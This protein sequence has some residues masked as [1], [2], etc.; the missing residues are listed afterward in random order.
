MPTSSDPAKRERQ[1]ANLRRGGTPA[2]EGNQHRVTHGAYAAIAAE[3]LDAK[4][5]EVF[6]ALVEDAPLKHTADSAAIRVAAEC[7]CRLDNVTGWLTDHGWLD[8]DNQPRTTILEIEGRLRR[9]AADH[10]DALGMTPRS[11]AKLGV[12]IARAADLA[13]MMSD[14]T[15]G[16]VS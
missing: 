9:E 11:R 7:L 5:L 16:V 1:L 6:D 13:Q 8:E 12:D 10:L 4:V 2:P 14:P 15:G 3:R